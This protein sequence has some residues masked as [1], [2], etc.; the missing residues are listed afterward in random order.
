[1]EKKNKNSYLEEHVFHGLNNLND[2]FDSRTI[3]YFSASDFDIVLLRVEKMGIE[4]Y[5]IEVWKDGEFFDVLSFEDFD[6]TPGNPGWYWKAFQ[7]FSGM[8]EELLYSASY[9]IP[10]S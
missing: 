10:R 2:G 3:K 7:K 9:H 1:M 5:G 6:T 8:Q 4:I